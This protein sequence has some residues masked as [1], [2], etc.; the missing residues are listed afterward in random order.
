MSDC[1]SA[2]VIH[3]GFPGAEDP[4]STRRIWEEAKAEK[5]RLNCNTCTRSVGF[6][7]AHMARVAQLV[8]REQRTSSKFDALGAA[9]QAQ[10][11][12]ITD[13]IKQ[14][15]HVCFLFGRLPHACAHLL[16]TLGICSVVLPIAQRRPSPGK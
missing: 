10:S 9:Q 1:C 12:R 3:D 2:A 8:E 6:R 13:L 4:L 11:R 14:M 5:K 15:V 7:L 16:A